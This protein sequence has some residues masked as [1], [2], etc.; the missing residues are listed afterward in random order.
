MSH[1]AASWGEV[2]PSGTEVRTEPGEGMGVGG[3]AGRNVGLWRTIPFNLLLVTA[4]GFW[5]YWSQITGD[6]LKWGGC[7]G[8]P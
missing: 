6:R 8:Q 7:G 3:A 5:N 1:K 4:E 2:T